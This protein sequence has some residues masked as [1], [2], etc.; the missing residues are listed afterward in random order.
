MRGFLRAHPDDVP[1]CKKKHVRGNKVTKTISNER[2]KQVDDAFLRWKVLGVKEIVCIT[3]KPPHLDAK[4]PVERM[5][6]WEPFVNRFRSYRNSRCKALRKPLSWWSVRCITSRESHPD[7]HM[8]EHMHMLV[9]VP[10]RE[11]ADHLIEVVQDTEDREGWGKNTQAQRVDAVE[12]MKGGKL[13]SFLN[14]VIKAVSPQSRRDRT[15]GWSPSGALVGERVFITRNLTNREVVAATEVGVATLKRVRE[16]KKKVVFI[17]RAR[18]H[19][20][21]LY[22]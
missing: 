1:F 22:G 3:M 21:G 11:E 14:Y 10:N 13:S 7:T 9:H 16:E 19:R 15:I 5:E 2:R 17:R 6:Y 8:G 20:L 4:D 12:Q 18:A